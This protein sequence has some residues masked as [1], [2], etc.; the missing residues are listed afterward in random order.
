MIRR[1]NRA[2]TELL[3]RIG[4]GERFTDKELGHLAEHTDV[5][6][7]PAGTQLAQAGAPVRQ[8]L[9]VLEGSVELRGLHGGV[10]G[11]GTQIGATELASGDAHP[12]TVTAELDSTL[13][14]IFG[15]AFRWAAVG[16]FE[17]RSAA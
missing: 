2:D 7:V 15:P 3:R 10:A 13:V 16:A 11:P 5:L 1:N 12:A 14:V 9:A 4:L 17:G 6:R 8:F